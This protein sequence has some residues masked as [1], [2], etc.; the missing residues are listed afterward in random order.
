[1]TKLSR[2]SQK[3]RRQIARLKGAFAE[4]LAS[5]L[6]RLKGYRILERGFRRPV[7]EVDIIAIRGN[8]LVAVEV[9]Q[10]PTIEMALGTIHT[11]QKRRIARALEA[12]QSSR[13]DM[14]ALDVRFDVILVSSF[15]KSPYHLENAW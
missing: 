13:S 10:R 14:I 15:F 2:K 12:Y 8:I 5:L 4:T 1:M 9:K 3:R 6:L 11:K 7:G